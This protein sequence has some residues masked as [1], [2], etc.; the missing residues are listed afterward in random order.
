MHVMNEGIDIDEAFLDWHL[1]LALAVMPR[2]LLALHS[3]N[4]FERGNI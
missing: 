4:D 1:S 3:V 2:H